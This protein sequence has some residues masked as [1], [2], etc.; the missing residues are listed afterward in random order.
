MIIA[1]IASSSVFYQWISYFMDG[2]TYVYTTWY[3]N[4]LLMKENIIGFFSSPRAKFYTYA[5]IK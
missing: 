1:I 4:R 3:V 2:K 5:F